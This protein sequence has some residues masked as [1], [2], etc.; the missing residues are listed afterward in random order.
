M[1]QIHTSAPTPDERLAL[2]CRN[3]G[4]ALREMAGVRDP[5]GEDFFRHCLT[6]IT[7]STHNMMGDEHQ[8]DTSK[9]QQ[10]PLGCTPSVATSASDTTIESINQLLEESR[11]LLRSIGDL[12]SHGQVSLG[13]EK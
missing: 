3:Y 5:E 13:G 1:V 9:Q 10:K 11:A 7:H 12:N 8:H 6:L 4:A 2:I